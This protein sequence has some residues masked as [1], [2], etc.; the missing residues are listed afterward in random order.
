MSVVKIVGGII[1]LFGAVFM[2][3]QTFIMVSEFGYAPWLINLAFSLAA[4]IGGV[5][6]IAGQRGAGWLALIVGLLSLILGLVSVALT[7]YRFWQYSLFHDTIGI[8]RMAGISIESL[9]IIVGGLIV[10]VSGEE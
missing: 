8:D 7:D 9:L 1:A 10:G 3:I 5:F 4:V 2:V 6:G